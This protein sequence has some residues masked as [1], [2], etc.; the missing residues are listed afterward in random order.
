M[1]Q[2]EKHVDVTRCAKCGCDRGGVIDLSVKDPVLICFQC[3][4]R[5]GSNGKR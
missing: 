2:D 4:K 1:A 3:A 5:K